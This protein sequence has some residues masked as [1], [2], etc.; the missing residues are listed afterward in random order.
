M[1]TSAN[2]ML[3]ST[4]DDALDNILLHRNQPPYQSSDGSGK[5]PAAPAAVTTAARKIEKECSRYCRPWIV[6]HSI[7]LFIFSALRAL[8]I[9]YFL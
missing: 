4:Q 6:K 3:S 9:I 8:T 5:A 1:Y 7:V 2:V